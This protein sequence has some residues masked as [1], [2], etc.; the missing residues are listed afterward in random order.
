MSNVFV[1]DKNSR[2]KWMRVFTASNGEEFSV[3]LSYGNEFER[4]SLT[5]EEVYTHLQNLL[6][7]AKKNVNG[8][9]LIQ[10]NDPPASTYVPLKGTYSEAQWAFEEMASWW[11]WAYTNEDFEIV[12]EQIA[13]ED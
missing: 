3:E 7:Y 1:Y 6:L 10:L 5:S 4:K 12:E 13:E 2:P 8:A 11:G 9:E